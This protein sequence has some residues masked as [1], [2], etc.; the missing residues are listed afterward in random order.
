MAVLFGFGK[1]ENPFVYD[2]VKFST[3]SFFSDYVSKADVGDYQ[4]SKYCKSGSCFIYQHEGQLDAIHILKFVTDKEVD[5]FFKDSSKL[6]VTFLQ[7]F[8]FRLHPLSVQ[9]LNKYMNMDYS[10]IGNAYMGTTILSGN[11][12]LNSERNHT[13]QFYIEK[14]DPICPETISEV[15]FGDVNFVN[16]SLHRIVR[17]IDNTNK[18]IYVSIFQFDSISFDDFYA[19]YSAIF[20]LLNNGN[21]LTQVDINHMKDQIKALHFPDIVFETYINLKRHNIKK[22]EL[23]QIINTA[24]SEFK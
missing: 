5:R 22:P 17:W 2:Y 4:D 13:I 8:Y 23:D 11:K 16:G 6:G 1:K 24:Y 9:I 15:R 19:S 10:N 3:E 18:Y 21:D 20:K 7:D 14:V 12:I